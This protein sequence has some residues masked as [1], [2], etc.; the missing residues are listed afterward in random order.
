[1]DPL[2]VILPTL[3][4]IVSPVWIS[5]ELNDE[6]AE[7]SGPEHAMWARI[8]TSCREDRSGIA[9]WLVLK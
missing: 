1:M 5:E 8:A 3:L 2:Y 9:S 7:L 6:A 4:D